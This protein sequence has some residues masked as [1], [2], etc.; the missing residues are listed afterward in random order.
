MTGTL[1]GVKLFSIECCLDSLMWGDT[2]W[3][4]LAFVA[5][6]V[7]DCYPEEVKPLPG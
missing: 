3:R 4:E 7:T 1:F 6:G 5:N 2:A